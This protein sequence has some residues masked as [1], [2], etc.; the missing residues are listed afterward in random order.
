MNDKM[1]ELARQAGFLFWQDEPHGPG[2]NKIDWSCDYSN[3]F[4]KYSKLLI[5]ETI[6]E[7]KL[8]QQFK[9]CD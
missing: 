7:L 6:N 3:E 5:K 9:P 8:D 2:S 1:I 4:D